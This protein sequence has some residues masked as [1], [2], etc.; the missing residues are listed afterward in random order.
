MAEGLFVRWMI[1]RDLHRVLEIDRRSFQQSWEHA[2]LTYFRRQQNTVPIVVESEGDIVG[3]MMLWLNKRSILIERI[4]VDHLNRRKGIG[5]LLLDR[6]KQKTSPEVRRS[7]V[8]NC[9]ERDLSAQLFLKA[10]D[11]KA[12]AVIND[13]FED[14]SSAYRF[15]WWHPGVVRAKSDSRAASRP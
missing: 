1:Q 13:H 15:E 10:A 14:G 7:I 5:T 6:V 8:Y 4:A 2:D 11:F 9:D 3:F 12:C